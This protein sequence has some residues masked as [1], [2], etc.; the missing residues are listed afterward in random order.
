MVSR[1]PI[2]WGRRRL[3]SLVKAHEN[4][5]TPTTTQASVHI[6]TLV[7]DD[8]P[9]ALTTLTGFLETQAAFQVVGVAGNGRE[10]LA[11]VAALHPALVLMDLQMPVMGGLQATRLIADRFPEVRVVVVSTHDSL[12]W[13]TASA[14]HGASGF[15]AKT[16]LGTDFPRLVSQLFIAAPAPGVAGA[17]PRA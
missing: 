6:R 11:Q 2:A 17:D 3:V 7:V 15:V 12:A 4:P 9:V 16:R 5:S 14:A 13:Q 10:A 1:I 8:S